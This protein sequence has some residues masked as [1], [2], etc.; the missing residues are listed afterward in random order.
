ML[1]VE[2]QLLILG[3]DPVLGFDGTFIEKDLAW[4]STLTPSLSLNY[5]ALAICAAQTGVYQ[6]STS[7]F[8]PPDV[9]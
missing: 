8:R 5:L 3:V 9:G 6:V 4:S 1:F 2:L 7:D